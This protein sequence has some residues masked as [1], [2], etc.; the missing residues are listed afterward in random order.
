[1]TIIQDYLVQ[2]TPSILGLASFVVGIWLLDAFLRRTDEPG[3]DVESC[4]RTGIK[5]LQFFGMAIGVV[6]FVTLFSLITVPLLEPLYR[7]ILTLVLLGLLGFVLLI[8][9]IA[10]VPWAALIALFVAIIASGILVLLSPL[11]IPILPFNFTY[12]LIAVFLITGILVFISLK[13]FE[14][15]IKAFAMILASRPI[16]FVLSIIG[17]I[18]AVLLFLQYPG[19]I[20]YF[21]PI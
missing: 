13:W 16:T 20:L 6:C 14:S 19:G 15:L 1:M 3:V 12:V 4:L 5:I 11:I 17:V 18:Q 7:D 8:A 10:K 21:L 2:L 9:P